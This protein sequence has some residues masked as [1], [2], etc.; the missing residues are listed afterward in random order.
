MKRSEMKPGTIF[1]IVGASWLAYC[2]RS[3]AYIVLDKKTEIGFWTGARTCVGE[4]APALW[5][6]VLT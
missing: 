4:V 2:G 1:G 6:E 3:E 5:F